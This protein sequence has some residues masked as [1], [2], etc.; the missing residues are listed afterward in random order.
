MT[1]EDIIRKVKELDLPA[2]SYIIF[3]SCPLAFADIREAGDIDMLVSQDVFD[4][5]QAEGWETKDKGPSDKPLVVGDFEAHSS[6]SFSHYQPTLQHLLETADYF[7]GIPVASI[8]EVK[9]W[10]IASGRP[11]DLRDIQL[12]NDYQKAKSEEA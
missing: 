11:K 3:G 1:K 12:I 4:K 10:K 9:K 6:W 5:L 7:E 2:D 8:E